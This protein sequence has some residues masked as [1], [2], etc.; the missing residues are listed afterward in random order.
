MNI[1]IVGPSIITAFSSRLLVGPCLKHVTGPYYFAVSLCD[2]LVGFCSLRPV[3][4]TDAGE[5]HSET[6]F[7]LIP[8]I[9]DNYNLGFMDR[10]DP[11]AFNTSTKKEEEN[12]N[13]GIDILANLA[14][15]LPLPPV[16]NPN[17]LQPP[18]FWM[19]DSSESRRESAAASTENEIEV[20]DANTP[21]SKRR[22]VRTACLP[23]RKRKSKVLLRH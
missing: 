22:L 8:L 7:H 18:W 6:S 20:K 1:L 17:L 5:D 3:L 11:P 23:C 19:S 16:S 2:Q 4:S 10:R 15:D 14:S 21:P 9:Q 13:L 12:N